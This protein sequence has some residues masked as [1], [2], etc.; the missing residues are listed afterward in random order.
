MLGVS[1]CA[2]CECASQD[3]DY[4]GESGETDGPLCDKWCGSRWRGANGTGDA[5]F[6]TPINVTKR[7]DNTLQHE[8]ST[9]F[10]LPSMVNQASAMAAARPFST[11]AEKAHGVHETPECK[12]RDSEMQAGVTFTTPVEALGL[13]L[14]G[15]APGRNRTCDLPLRSKSDHFRHESA[16]IPTACF[17]AYPPPGRRLSW[18]NL[19]RGLCLSTVAEECR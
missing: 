15:G 10:F 19:S 2:L 5:Y 7:Q 16:A 13:V 1:F 3:A 8:R 12:V 18:V 4:D 14:G 17:S 9:Q 11:P 6:N